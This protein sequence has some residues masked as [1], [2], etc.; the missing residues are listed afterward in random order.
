M[1]AVQTVVVV[2]VLYVL[3][4]AAR[5]IL[6]DEARARI[7]DL[8][9]TMLRLAAR[10]LPADERE[11]WL[12]DW[13]SNLLIPLLTETERYPLTRFLRSWRFGFDLMLHA[14]RIRAELTATKPPVLNLVAWRKA[15]VDTACVTSLVWV[16]LHLLSPGTFWGIFAAGVAGVSTLGIEVLTFK[17]SYY[18]FDTT[19]MVVEAGVLRTLLGR[20]LI[21]RLL[22]LVLLPLAVL[23]G[24]AH[25]ARGGSP[26]RMRKHRDVKRTRRAPR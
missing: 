17:R 2:V 20:K 24:I 18:A 14:T 10:Q 21:F 7:D 22:M 8:P 11:K 5:K 6:G 4:S 15:A 3:G 9:K 19:P 12:I 23:E 1:S 26:R 16:P 13:E 25:V